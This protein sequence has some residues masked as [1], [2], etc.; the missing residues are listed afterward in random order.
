MELLERTALGAGDELFSKAAFARLT[1]ASFYE[2]CDSYSH[3]SFSC[4]RADGM[5]DD[6]AR[7]FCKHAVAAAKNKDV[8]RKAQEFLKYLETRAK[9]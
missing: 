2:P 8:R 7:A 9:N 4:G 6:A 5:T 1:G 3:R